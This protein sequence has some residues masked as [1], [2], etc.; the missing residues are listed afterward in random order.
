[1]GLVVFLETEKLPLLLFGMTMAT[2]EEITQFSLEIEKIAVEKNV[3]YMDAIVLYCEQTGFEIELAAKL[4][5]N[6][7]KAKI[8]LEAEK[9][10]FLPKSNT[11]KLPL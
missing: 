6:A 2:R 11:G 3:S 5:S 10:N 9:L 1:L 7:L 8:R 4:I